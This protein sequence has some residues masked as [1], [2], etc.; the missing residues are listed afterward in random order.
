M[1]GKK[2]TVGRASAVIGPELERALDRM[3]STTYAE[4][5]HQ[6]E[7]IAA[8]VTEH[9]KTNWYKNV[10]ERTG[11]TGGGIDYEIRLTPDKLKGVI[12]SD[13]KATYYVHRP[14]ALSQIGRRVDSSE[15]A[16]IM[17]EYRRTGRVPEGYSV[18]RFTRTRR[19]V[20]VFKLS[21]PPGSAPRDG[22]NLW[23]LLVIDYAKRLVKE[24]IDDID[25]ALQ[26]VAR[27]VAA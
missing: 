26:T 19:P 15:F 17:M 10:Q 4:V 23:K 9:A 1:A 11:K 27:R 16:A 12:A 6:V 25:K 20:G 24:R 7:G 18:E 8:D 5:K 2:I 22:K 21:P 3:I 14:G 13:V